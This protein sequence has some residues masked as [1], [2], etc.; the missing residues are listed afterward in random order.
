MKNF[1]RVLSLALA[2]L[3]VIGGL[4]VAPV[5]AKA[6]AT[7]TKVTSVSE[8][9][10]GGDFVL[11]ATSGSNNYALGTTIASKVTGKAVTVAN[12]TVSGS[13][14]PVWT[15][16]SVSGD[17]VTLSNGTAYLGYNSG[18]NFQSLTDATNN[19]A[20]WT[21]SAEGDGFKFVNVNSSGRGI[22]YQLTSS[23]FRFGAYAT[24]NLTNADYDFGLMVFKVSGESEGPAP[25]VPTDITLPANA[26]PEEII[27]AAYKAQEDGVHLL[28]T[29]EL[30]GVITTITDR[31]EGGTDYQNVD[32]TIKV[33]D[34]E[35]VMRC[36]RVV[37]GANVTL[38]DLQGLAVGDTITVKGT[39]SYYGSSVQFVQNSTIEAVEK[40]AVVVPDIELPANATP[41]QIIDAAY[42]AK[43]TGVQ[44]LGTWTLTGVIT[45]ITDKYEGG[46]DYQNVDVT[47]KVGDIEKVMRCYRVVNGTDVT[48]DDLQGLAVGDTITVTGRISYYGDSVQ[49]VQNSTIDAIEK[50]T[51]DDP[52]GSEDDSTSESESES[53]KESEKEEL[54][55]KD[56]LAEAAKLEDGQYLGGSKDVKYTL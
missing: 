25:E 40:A 46:S 17:V 52:N 16:A 55:A 3:M 45:T 37:N 33:G 32:V 50:A 51:V 48:L 42:E 14:I 9:T 44:L 43:E 2:A 29:W 34:I 56:I 39:I 1:K 47:I 4:V 7:Y 23:D 15:V 35:R 36:Y 20:H 6:D 19:K 8:I 13:S 54:T 49:F 18:T 24:T 22:A 41:Q 10:A 53:E 12:N 11:V 38:D 30:T 21:V 26:T 27:N 31:Y 28:G 5:D